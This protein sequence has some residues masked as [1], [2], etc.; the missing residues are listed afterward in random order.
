[1]PLIFWNFNRNFNTK[2]TQ[3]L[4]VFFIILMKIL[5]SFSCYNLYLI[6][7]IYEDNNHDLKRNWN[8]WHTCLFYKI[9]PHNISIKRFLIGKS[10]VCHG[11]RF[12]AVIENSNQYKIFDFNNFYQILHCFQRKLHQTRWHNSVA[13]IH[14]RK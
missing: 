6:N 4:T 14:L 13:I 5:R 10:R 12:L 9:L 1:M 8:S 3:F 7:I 2:F 11:F